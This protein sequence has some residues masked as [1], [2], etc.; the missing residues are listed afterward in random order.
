MWQEQRD[1][2]TEHGSDGELKQKPMQ[3]VGTDIEYRKDARRHE[4]SKVK[5]GVGCLPSL[6]SNMLAHLQHGHSAA[7]PRYREV[8]TQKPGQL[9]TARPGATPEQAETQTWTQRFSPACFHHH[10]ELIDTA[11]P[12]KCLF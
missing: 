11:Q 1:G 9:L 12:E 7:L 2:S 8:P 3:Y 10:F 4:F 5:I 6:T